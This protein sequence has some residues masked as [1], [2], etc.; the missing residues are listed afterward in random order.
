MDN[1]S[2]LYEEEESKIH[3]KEQ[4]EKAIRD[5]A[6]KRT[7]LAKQEY[8]DL[9][10][11]LESEKLQKSTQAQNFNNNQPASLPA[12]IAQASPATKPKK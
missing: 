8:R 4:Q 6:K 9:T 3:V 10:N 12:G 7:D 11:E 2:K 1:F 5:H